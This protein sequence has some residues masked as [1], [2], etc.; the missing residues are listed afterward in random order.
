MPSSEGG[1]EDQR[2]N[3]LLSLLQRPWETHPGC[4]RALWGALSACPS[5]KWPWVPSQEPTL[6]LLEPLSLWARIPQ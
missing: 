6:G 1:W 2:L 3:F 5:G 4:S